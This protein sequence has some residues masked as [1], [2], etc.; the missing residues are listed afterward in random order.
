MKYWLSG[1]FSLLLASSAWAQD[2]QIVQSRS[3]KLDIW[4]DNVKS[5]SPQSWCARELPLRIVANGKKDPALLDDFLPR[6]ASL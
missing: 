1:A 4:I 6:V 5:N 2:Y 3:L